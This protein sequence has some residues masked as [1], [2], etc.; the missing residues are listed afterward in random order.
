VES[1]ISDMDAIKGIYDGIKTGT[2]GVTIKT[3]DDSD[4]KQPK[5]LVIGGAGN[6]SQ[7]SLTEEE[8]IALKNAILELRNNIVN[9]NL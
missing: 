6:E 4:S 7:P 9:G 1:T 5:K 2:G 8:F 3:S